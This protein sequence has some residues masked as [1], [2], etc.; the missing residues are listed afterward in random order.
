MTDEKE[1]VIMDDEIVDMDDAS[2]KDTDADSD[3]DEESD[4][5]PDSELSDEED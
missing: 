3:I 5:E 2:K 1:P 4:E